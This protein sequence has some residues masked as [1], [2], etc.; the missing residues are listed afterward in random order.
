MGKR[1]PQPASMGLL[2]VWDFEFYKAFHSLRDG[3]AL[4][5]PNLPPPSGFSRS[6][7]RAILKRMKSMSAAEYWRVQQQMTTEFTENVD[8]GQ[9]PTK[10]E[11]RFAN[12]DLKE[13][14]DWLE[15]VLIPQKIHAQVE[16]RK[17]W[18]DLILAS[19]YAAVRNG[20]QHWSQLSDVRA[21]G[22]NTFPEHVR[23]NTGQFLSM[24][25]NKRFPRSHYGDDARMDYLARGMA[26]VLVGVSPMTAIE[27]LR[28]LKHAPGGPL[29]NTSEHRCKC[30]R[31]H[32]NISNKIAGTT[33]GWYENGLQRFIE[34]ADEMKRQRF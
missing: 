6:E 25:E 10:D 33:Q 16:R 14:T 18:D 11:I 32:L 8:L 4:P 12:R 23:A 1:G 21:P 5:V 9:V 27:R 19:T 34:I 30:W 22:L 28:N 13:E 17:I 24:K 20:C 26:G 7:L 2:N 31:C 29:W 3:I 15:R